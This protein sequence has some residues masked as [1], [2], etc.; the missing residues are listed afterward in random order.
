LFG[1]LVS[2]IPL[3]LQA[4]LA[5]LATQLPLSLCN[6]ICTNIP[7]PQQPLYLL[8]HKMLR[9]YPYVPIGGE[10]GVNVAILSYDGTAYFGFGGDVHA[11]PDIE[12]FEELL[13]VSFKELREAAVE[14]APLAEPS[15][16]KAKVEASQRTAK[17]KKVAATPATPPAR[18]KVKV[19][20]ISTSK[21]ATT[22]RRAVATKKTVPF[23]PATHA[24]A[25]AVAVPAHALAQTG[26]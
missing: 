16:P 19:K 11:V 4:V 13:R 18:S 1:A 20:L 25:G 7:G 23:P 26:D 14:K 9:A 5:P 2:K 8:G 3:P 12:L 15:A 21:P 10:M 24:Q 17:R 6:M 22:K